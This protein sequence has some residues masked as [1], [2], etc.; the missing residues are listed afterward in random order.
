MHTCHRAGAEQPHGG[1]IFVTVG[2][3]DIAPFE[4]RPDL[5]LLVRLMEAAEPPAIADGRIVVA[6]GPFETEDEM[7][8]M[9][10]NRIDCVATKNAGGDA[11]YAK[12]A[13]ARA[14]GLPVIMVRRP[15]VP[16]TESVATVDAAIEWLK[17]RLT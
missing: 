11:T 6:S 8:L 4:N 7:R 15:P 2:R 3:G 16:E 17:A 12:I 14:L 10:S 1:R 13:A 9:T 5:W